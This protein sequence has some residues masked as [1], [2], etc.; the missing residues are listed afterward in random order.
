MFLFRIFKPLISKLVC[1][2][3]N[4]TLIT[5]LLFNQLNK[6]HFVMSEKNSLTNKLLKNLSIKQILFDVFDDDSVFCQNIIDPVQQ[7]L[8]QTTHTCSY[9]ARLRTSLSVHINAEY[10]KS[11]MTSLRINK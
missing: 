9:A 6:H 1:Q 10:G 3:I 7:H 5:V 2:N 11:I 4:F 8:L